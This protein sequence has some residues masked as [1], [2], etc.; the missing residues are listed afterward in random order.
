MD[1]YQNSRN[2]MLAAPGQRAILYGN[3][4]ENFMVDK[5]MDSYEMHKQQNV[6]EG[7]YFMNYFYDID[8]SNIEE[9]KDYLHGGAGN[10]PGICL[11]DKITTTKSLHKNSGR[12]LIAN[13]FTIL[14]EFFRANVFFS[15]NFAQ[16]SQITSY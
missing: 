4:K 3:S 10:L 5:Y 2:K 15:N 8:Q 9:I 6:E 12:T 14:R 1:M 16:D 11:A 7:R 13:L